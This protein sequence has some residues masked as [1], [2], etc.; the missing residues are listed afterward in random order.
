MNAVQRSSFALRGYG[1]GQWLGS[2]GNCRHLYTSAHQQRSSSLLT[3]FRTTSL[4]IGRDAYVPY[5]LQHLRYNST[6]ETNSLDQEVIRKEVQKLPPKR[7][8][9]ERLRPYAA[10]ARIDKPTGTLLLFLPCTWSLTLAAHAHHLPPGQLAWNVFLF[11][12]GAFIMR[13]AGCTINDMWD[14][15]LDAN[16]ARTKDRPLASGAVTPFQA[17]Y[18][19]GIQLSAG[20]AILLQ[21]NMYSIALGASSLALVVIYPF[22]KRITYWPHSFWV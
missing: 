14:R 3:S 20:L 15:K 22:M 9:I 17:L 16:V 2:S 13:G 5:R 4:V 21:L 18:F 11:G 1:M 10:L 8:L 12:S 19:T 6:T 7:S